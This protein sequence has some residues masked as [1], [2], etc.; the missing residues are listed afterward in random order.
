MMA[1]EFAPFCRVNAVLPGH[2]LEIVPI[3]LKRIFEK[4]L[5]LNLSLDM[6]LSK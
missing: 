3:R 4:V 2:V 5:N 6:V 1:K